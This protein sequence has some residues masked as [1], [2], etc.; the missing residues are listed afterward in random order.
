MANQLKFAKEV[1][2]VILC[3]HD[4]KHWTLGLDNRHSCTITLNYERVR[5]VDS[6]INQWS[7]KLGGNDQ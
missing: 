2:S 7:G 3:L 5:N 6:L 4:I 1:S